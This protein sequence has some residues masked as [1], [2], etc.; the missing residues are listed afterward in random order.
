MTKHPGGRV[1]SES[2]CDGSADDANDLIGAGASDLVVLRALGKRQRMAKTIRQTTDGRSVVEPHD[3][4]RVFQV[5]HARTLKIDDIVQAGRALARVAADEF[6]VRGAIRA[7]AN[8]RRMR[9]LLHPKDNTPATMAEVPRAYVLFDVDGAEP[10]IDFDP[11]N[12]LIEE[13]GP[14][15]D[16]AS[17]APWEAAIDEF[18]REALPPAF[19]GTSCWWQFTAGMGFKP[20]LHMRLLFILDR[21]M[22]GDDLKRWLGPQLRQRGLASAVFGPV[23]QILVAPPMLKDGITD[24]SAGAPDG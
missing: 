14:P 15:D 7:S 24:R 10:L 17:F 20:G 23:Q 22:L 16:P 5:S 18:I 4:R 19:H 13:Q 8:T 2:G 12:Q 6:V 1:A 3:G 11:R 21:P 9:R